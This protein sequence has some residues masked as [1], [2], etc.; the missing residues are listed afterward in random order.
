MQDLASDGPSQFQ[1]FA[2]KCETRLQMWTCIF[3]GLL[4]AHFGHPFSVH[5]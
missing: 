4:C 2:I 5:N 1:A 3:R